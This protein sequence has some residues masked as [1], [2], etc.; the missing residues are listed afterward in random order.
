MRGTTLQDLSPATN[1]RSSV[2]VPTLALLA[3]MYGLLVGNFFAFNENWFALPVYMLVAFLAIHLSF[4]IWHEAAHGNV[5]KYRWLNNVIGVLGM[6]PYF[7]PYFHTRYLHLRHHAS[8]N[9]VDDPNRIYL[10][11]AFG[12]LFARWRREIDF[13]AAAMKTA[14]LPLREKLSDV[15]VSMVTITIVVAGIIMGQWRG[16]VFLW[17][18]PFLFA[19][20]AVDWYVN[21]LPHIGLP[22]D[23][24][25]GTRIIPTSWL[26]P[27]VLCHNYHAV[28][29]L[30]P[31]YPWYRY[32]RIFA[33]RYYELIA[34]KV[35]V[36][37]GL[38]KGQRSRA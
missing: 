34:N 36:E 24:L 35:P 4:T 15:I 14:P 8:L 26:T 17:F 33:K 5:S 16:V 20:F 19:K 2:D 28:H 32:P 12:N 30:W 29:H 10:D 31:Q 6:V 22:A 11:G 1:A 38:P 27:L 3:V 37:S 18:V 25:K 7:A 9:D 23:R 21:Y 13:Y